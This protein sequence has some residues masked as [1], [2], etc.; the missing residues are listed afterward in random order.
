MV[1]IELGSVRVFRTVQ[2]GREVPLYLF[3]PGDLFGFMP[4]LDGSPYPA[5]AVCVEDVSARVLGRAE[6]ERLLNERPELSR[7]L[8]AALSRRLRSAFAQ[9]EL[10]TTRGAV[11]R[12]AATL[13]ALIPADAPR[14]LVVS[15]PVSGQEL[16]E[17]L[18]LTP[19]TLSRALGELES[20][21]T[22]HKLGSRRYQVLDEQALA[23][24][25][26]RA[27]AAPLVPP[28]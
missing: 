25:A 19:P 21:G 12:V 6:L 7:V 17:S 1:L 11:A 9:I 5:S 18:G 27:T 10:L 8:L 22:I 16:A 15:L 23:R 26:Q 14:P 2:D 13:T 4:L 3:R 28:L 20:C 24:V